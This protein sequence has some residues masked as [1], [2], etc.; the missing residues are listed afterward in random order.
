MNIQQMRLSEQAF[1]KLSQL[2]LAVEL[3]EHKRFSVRKEVEP[4]IELLK[5]ACR[6][7]NTVV[8][9]KLDDLVDN[10]SIENLGFFQTLGIELKSDPAV[11]TKVT[12]RG[13]AVDGKPSVAEPVAS[14]ALAHVGKKK[15]IYRGKVMYQ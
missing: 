7:A 4:V 6:S 5:V 12:Y 14:A 15:I 1:G 8:R 11:K 3:H 13:R 10:F 9:E 2:A